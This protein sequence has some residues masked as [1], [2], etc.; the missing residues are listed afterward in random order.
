MQH[1]LNF[2]NSVMNQGIKGTWFP[3]EIHNTLQLMA[4][5]RRCLLSY[6]SH[7]HTEAM[8]HLIPLP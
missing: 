3:Q 4:S 2:T 8:E 1:D 7:R 6:L 5:A